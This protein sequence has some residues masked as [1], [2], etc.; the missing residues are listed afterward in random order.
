[1]TKH[2]V[3]TFF[4]G[5][6]LSS[7]TATQPTLAMKKAMLTATLGDE[8]KAEDPTTRQLEKMVA[9]LLGLEE[10]LFF[11]SATIK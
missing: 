2:P 9:E 1:M 5:I 8:Q 10:A 6:D 7:D 3:S 11:P 4:S